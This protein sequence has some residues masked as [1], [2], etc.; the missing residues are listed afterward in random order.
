[1][2]RINDHWSEYSVSI[3]GHTLT[4]EYLKRG[5]WWDS[6]DVEAVFNNSG[7]STG[8]DLSYY[9]DSINNLNITVLETGLGNSLSTDAL[10]NSESNTWSNYKSSTEQE[11]RDNSYQPDDL[12]QNM[13]GNRYGL[14][15]QHA[16][17]NGTFYIDN[18]KGFI[19]FGSALAGRNVILHYVSDGL[20]TDSEMVVHKFAEE[21]V[22]KWI[23]H[24]VI[25]SR[26][27]MP[28]YIVQ[29]FKKEK[30]A[31][32]RKAKIRLSNIKIEEF[33]QVLK[34]LSKPIK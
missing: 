2:E 12:K 10:L 24:A 29:R 34:G 15:P 6:G 1:M 27:N 22:Y 16:Q 19:H 26:S 23:A 33:A 8:G 25:A 32:A 14:D 18:S 20:G 9:N 11:Y 4:V 31:E 28:E 17:D 13:F 5:D 3:S 7:S 30:F 21:A